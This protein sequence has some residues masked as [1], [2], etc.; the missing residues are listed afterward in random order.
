MKKALEERGYLKLA[1]SEHTYGTYQTHTRGTLKG[2]RHG[3]QMLLDARNLDFKTGSTTAWG[4][5]TIFW[6]T[7]SASGITAAGR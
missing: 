2:L 7:T 4:W 1:V 3:A 6:K 5:A